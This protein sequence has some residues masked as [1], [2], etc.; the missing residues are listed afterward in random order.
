MVLTVL[1]VPRLLDSGKSLSGSVGLL[2]SPWSLA[3]LDME[4]AYLRPIDLC[5]TQL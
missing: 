1:Y 3:M 2:R 5:I 4:G